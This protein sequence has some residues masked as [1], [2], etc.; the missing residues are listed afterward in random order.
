MYY[1]AKK[2][3]KPINYSSYFHNLT[4][5]HICLGF[6]STSPPKRKSSVR[7]FHRREIRL[8]ARL[9]LIRFSTSYFKKQNHFLD[10]KRCFG[11]WERCARRKSTAEN[12]E[13]AKFN[14]SQSIEHQTRP[15]FHMKYQS[16]NKTT[17]FKALSA[18][19]KCSVE[20][21]PPLCDSCWGNKRKRFTLYEEVFFSF[22]FFFVR[23]TFEGGRRLLS[24]IKDARDSRASGFDIRNFPVH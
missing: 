16:I 6:T 17:C 9:K 4:S 1:R 13:N 7:N 2:K 11:A 24:T 14:K 3:L 23:L 21:L 19:T 10:K 20:F 18:Y 5:F 12:S 22:L 8:E 15:I